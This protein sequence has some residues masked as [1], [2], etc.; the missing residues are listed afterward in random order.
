MYDWLTREITGGSFIITANHRLAKTL[1][2]HFNAGEKARGLSVWRT[3]NIRSLDSWILECINNSQSG[4]RRRTR[5]GGH[6]S[7]LVW[8]R[9]LPRQ[10]DTEFLSRAAFVREARKA[11][12][13]LKEWDL[14]LE[15][16]SRFARSSDERLFL[17]CARSYDASLEAN[18]WF[19][20]V[21]L[22]GEFCRLL[23]AG[24]ISV[25]Q[26]LVFAGFDRKTP[27]FAR[28]VGSLQDAGVAI[29]EAP[30]PV[31]EGR[32]GVVTAVTT[33]AELRSAG[34]WARKLLLAE[35]HKR[36]AIVVPGLE[37]NAQR[38][39]RLIREGLV[40]GWQGDGAELASCLN[41]SYG[42]R[43][44]EYPMVETA[45]LLLRWIT[46]GINFSEVSI[47]LRSPFLGRHDD[48]GRSQA[49]RRLREEPDR[50]WTRE[51][52]V[53]VLERIEAASVKDWT[54]R[55]RALDKY[56]GEDG[57]TQPSSIWA[58][59]FAECLEGLGWPGE[60]SLRSSE[61]Q[62]VNRWRQLLNEF[63]RL[64]SVSR[65][66][67]ASQASELLASIANEVVFQAQRP[68]G[69]VDLLGVLETSGMEFD[70]IWC[71][72]M[73]AN[74]WPVSAQPVNLL[75]RRLQIEYG[76]PDATP[77]D[78]LQFGKGL[79][80]RLLASADDVV[81]S[82][83][84]LDDE[85]ELLPSPY[86]EFDE[87]EPSF[88]ARDPGWYAAG[89][90]GS[91]R[92][93][94]VEPDPVPPAAAGEKVSGGAYTIQM[95]R[96]EPLGALVAGRLG[97]EPLPQVETGISAALR[98]RI[99]HRALQQLYSDKPSQAEISGW[100]KAAL[101]EKLSQAATEG[102]R[103]HIANADL[104]LRRLL[105]FERDRLEALLAQFVT[106]ERQRP[107]FTVAGIEEEVELNLDGLV[108]SVRVDRIDR[109]NGGVLILDY[110]SGAPKA[111]E[112]R[113]GEIAHLQ[114][115]VY[116]CALEGEVLGLVLANLDSRQ[117]VY[118][119]AGIKDVWSA[120]KDDEDSWRNKLDAWK[121]EV[122]LHAANLK[123]GDARV[124]VQ[125]PSKDARPLAVVSRIAELKRAE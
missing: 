17:H 106:A 85:A 109:M 94:P 21:S 67:S 30:T 121:R 15:D 79:F 108:I 81:L 7:A 97:C 42:R 86:L 123:N 18:A 31:R 60:R 115:A 66:L 99:V 12:R 19:D 5:L 102:I 52:V 124:N 111:V 33:E 22:S 20:D 48:S 51:G 122:R 3:P 65:P 58:K 36:I 118:K 9:C 40:P 92:S 68:G 112:N 26:R 50:P 43:L 64:D 10:D 103:R 110:K 70:A 98:G 101:A 69:T 125:L 59:S 75:P 41:V 76:M 14:T 72:G 89:L 56:A 95:Q 49:E 28:L 8:E 4:G 25:P 13:R 74:R 54:E 83:A 116:A 78:S 104:V 100:E 55:I 114:L 1:R 35:P 119:G 47:L 6:A 82:W 27:L 107:P 32:A 2:E 53:K 45:L 23:E 91:H 11:W 38:Y 57:D 77:E 105:F 87:G 39:A 44:A 90:G 88:A 16:L 62:L 63:A 37:Q 117:V 24:A 80:E 73:D 61:F 29:E 46:T 71:A 93:A 96:T 113:N 84:Q 120:W 34:D